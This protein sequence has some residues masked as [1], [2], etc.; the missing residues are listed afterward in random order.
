[1]GEAKRRG[2]AHARRQ[3]ALAG[4]QAILDMFHS[5]QAPHYAIIL[6]KS[7]RALNMLER[8]KGGPDELRA[9][10]TSGAVQLWELAHFQY[11]VIW[12]TWGMSGGLTVQALDL[13]KLLH[14]ALPEVMARTLEKGGLCMFIPGVSDD[15]IDT[16][17]ARLAELQPTEGNP[18]MTQ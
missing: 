10:A 9:R 7:P 2:T 16:V 1:M 8:L 14:Q 18:G 3:Q 11:V 12:G 17:M 13:D 4:N 6:D 5:G 15:V